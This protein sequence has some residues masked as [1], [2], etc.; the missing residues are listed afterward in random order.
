MPLTSRVSPN[1]WGRCA[2]RE[3]KSQNQTFVYQLETT[4]LPQLGINPAIGRLF[5]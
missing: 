5:D 2:N 1:P 4:G 3:V